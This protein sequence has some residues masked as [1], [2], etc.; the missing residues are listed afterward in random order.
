[1]IRVCGVLFIVFALAGLYAY[2]EDLL[3][4]AEIDYGSTLSHTWAYY[5]IGAIFI[6]L[7]EITLGGVGYMY[8]RTPAKA[9]FLLKL[10]VVYILVVAV[11]FFFTLAFTEKN[12]FIPGWLSLK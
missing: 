4:I 8:S 7:V 3:N 12:L 2:G 9:V 11:W 10:G 1:M 5:Y 6:C